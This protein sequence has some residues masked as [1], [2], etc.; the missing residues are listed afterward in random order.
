LKKFEVPWEGKQPTAFFRGTA[1]GGGV[2]TQTNQRLHLAALSSEWSAIPERNGFPE[3]SLG[4]TAADT[5]GSHQHPYLD[6][7]IVGWNMRDKKIAS[8][9]MTFIDKVAFDY[10]GNL[11]SNFV[12]IYKQGTY[13]YVIYVEGHCAACRYGFMMLLGSVILKVDSLCVADQM[14]YFP[15]LVPF[16]DHVPVKSD[17]S[18]LQ[19]KIEWCRNNDD[20]CREIVK[21]ARKLYDRIL[22]K[23]GILDYMQ[24]IFVEMAS[25]RAVAPEWASPLPDTMDPPKCA[26]RINAYCDEVKISELLFMDIIVCH[27]AARLLCCMQGKASNSSG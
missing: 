21:N 22:C 17:L 25:H 26:A 27:L 24:G 12:E 10:F 13:K 4:E 6:A 23:E 15:I 14:W 18:D 8:S 1:T 16:E 3:T 11:K 5:Q 7:K 19:E 9:K 20:K 2:T